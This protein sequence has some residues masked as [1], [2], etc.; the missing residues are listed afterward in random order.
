MFWLLLL[1]SCC[2]IILFFFLITRRPP[3]STRT[4]TLVPYTT[5]F[6]SHVRRYH[7]RRAHRRAAWP[8]RC[9]RRGHP[10]AAHLQHV[11]DLGHHHAVMHLLGRAVRRRHHLYPIQHS[12]GAVVGRPPLRRLSPR[13]VGARTP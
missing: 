1:V 12:R 3:G 4:Y 5:L 7:A 2:C 6:R 9:Q 11:A 13:A 8:R 10:A